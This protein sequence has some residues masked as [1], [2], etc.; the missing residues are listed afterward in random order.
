MKQ[1]AEEFLCNG[2]L[3]PEATILVQNAIGFVDTFQGYMQRLS[4]SGIPQSTTETLEIDFQGVQDVKDCIAHTQEMNKARDD[5][6]A[7]F[8]VVS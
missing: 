6:M 2:F 7:A 1:F 3:S 4:S 5:G 8:F